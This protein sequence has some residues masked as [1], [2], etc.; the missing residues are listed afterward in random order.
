MPPLH[1]HGWYRPSQSI[2]GRCVTLEGLLDPR[3]NGSL[4]AFAFDDGPDHR[5][6]ANSILAALVHEIVEM[7]SRAN[8]EAP[9]RYEGPDEYVEFEVPPHLRHGGYHRRRRRSSGSAPGIPEGAAM[10]TRLLS[11]IAADPGELE[12][13]IDSLAEGP[14]HDVAGTIVLLR[15]LESLYD[16]LG[17]ADLPPDPTPEPTTDASTPSTTPRSSSSRSGARSSRARG[18]EGLDG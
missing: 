5:R 18:G 8:R 3:D 10:P 1:H 13:L 17:G 14:G 6:A 2:H 9:R 7:A 16:T 4:S 15:L 12:Y 11:R